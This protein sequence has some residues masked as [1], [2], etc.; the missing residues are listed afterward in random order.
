[1]KKL[2]IIHIS[3][4]D[5]WRGGEQQLLYL[6]DELEIQ[7]VEQC[8]ICPRSS[9]LFQ[10]LKE[11]NIV[12][13]GVQKVPVKWMN[14]AAKLKRLNSDQFFNIVHTHDAGALTA[15]YFAST[16]LKVHLPTVA[17]RR[18][19]IRPS[20]GRLTYRK[21]T[22]PDLWKIVCVSK[23]I[24]KVMQ[25]Y[26]QSEDKLHVIYS[27]IDMERFDPEYDGNFL[28]HKYGIDKYKLLVGNAS[29]IAPH[30]D[31]HT[32][33]K[34][35]ANLLNNRDD[36]HFVIMGRNDGDGENVRK[37]IQELDLQEH[38]TLTGFLE[39]VEEAMASLDL[40]LNT[41]KTEG[42]GTSILEAMSAKIPVVATAAGGIPEIVQN[43]VNGM[44]NAIEDVTGLSNSALSLL[45]DDEKRSRIQSNAF[46]SVEKFSKSKM[47]AQT[48]KLY[49]DIHNS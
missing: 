36:L 47:A 1:V 40:Y 49:R 38:V 15:A 8:V 13:H 10:K 45:N 42:L 48:L 41:S 4:P 18:I 19:D 21:Y 23:A 6:I 22:Y 16:V 31:Y 11:R 28:K 37:W 25:A 7:H 5:S 17:A 39:N 33:L 9:V 30:K 27:G 26:L 34:V 29:A 3:T 24:Y 46:D 35:A 14:A 43:E 44:L 12:L 32:F 2:R 20:S